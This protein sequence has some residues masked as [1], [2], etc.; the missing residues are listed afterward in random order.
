MT[1]TTPTFIHWAVLLSLGIIWGASFMGVTVALEGFTPC[2]LAAT[3]ITIAALILLAYV[4]GTGRV[5]PPLKG[6]ARLWLH[7]LS[8]AFFSNALP[9]VLLSWGQLQ[10]TS[11]FSGVCMAAVPLLVVPLAHA[12]V[13]GERMTILKSIGFLIGF[14]GTLVLM[15]RG[16]FATSGSDLEGLARIACLGAAACYAIGSITTRTA[17][18]TGQAGFA[19]AGLILAAL[20]ILPLALIMDGWPTLGFDVRTLAVPYLSV[21]PT[22][23]ATIRL[24]FWIRSAVPSCLSLV[25]YQVPVWS[26]VFGGFL[27]GEVFPP[28]LFLAL[29][30]ILA[31]IVVSQVG[32]RLGRR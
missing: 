13:P 23:L 22:A 15:G 12:F 14:G 29:T 9:F 16:V 30:L 21:G 27:L 28:S 4:W 1:S 19:A 2:Q 20:M 5:L 3:R 32:P 18:P 24:I 17:P 31:G 8:F 26:V 11:G 10:V 25:N 6:A 7:I